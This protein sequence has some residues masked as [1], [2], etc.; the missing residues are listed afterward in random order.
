[1]LPAGT[2]EK[3]RSVLRMPSSTPS[4][5]AAI[6]AVTGLALAAH[7]QCRSGPAGPGMASLKGKAE[8]QGPLAALLRGVLE[9]LWRDAEARSRQC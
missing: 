4:A 1:M 7:E 5:S 8:D 3:T 6:P 2:R 9:M